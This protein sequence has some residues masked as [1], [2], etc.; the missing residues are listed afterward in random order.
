MG[1]IGE[2]GGEGLLSTLQH[3]KEFQKRWKGSNHH[4]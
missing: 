1:G 4:N 3:R 2:N